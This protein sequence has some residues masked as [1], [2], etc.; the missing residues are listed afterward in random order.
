MRISR[1]RRLTRAGGN[2]PRWEDLSW[3]TR[4]PRA[5]MIPLEEGDPHEVVCRHCLEMIM[6]ERG[7]LVVERLPG[8][9]LVQI[10]S[11][12]Y[13][14]LYSQEWIDAFAIDASH[15]EFPYGIRNADVLLAA[16]YQCAGHGGNIGF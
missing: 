9:S 16:R 12:C 2:D 8:M 10:V 4:E 6:T 1:R 5:W 11:D 14:A 3:M 13:Q 15:P 7:L